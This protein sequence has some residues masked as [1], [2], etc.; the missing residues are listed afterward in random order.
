MGVS[1]SSRAGVSG[2]RRRLLALL[3]TAGL[4]A[5]PFALA[6]A[7]AMA[8]AG[9]TTT[10]S[11]SSTG[12]TTCTATGSTGAV[13]GTCT[14]TGAP[15]C[16]PATAGAGA[17]GGSGTGAVNTNLNTLKSEL[18]P[19]IGAIFANPV[20]APLVRLG[21]FVLDCIAIWLLG[22][23]LVGLMFKVHAQ[24]QG[25]G[26]SHENLHGSLFAVGVLLLIVAGG[27]IWLL[28]GAVQGISALMHG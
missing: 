15:Y 7:P 14:V 19:N 17:S 21:L 18:T 20:T 22:S 16:T 3:V 11:Q 1:L 24:S 6:A 2:V 8:A 23:A 4:G 5:A 12:T 25:E 28:T 9:A 10:C 27:G 13:V 26:L